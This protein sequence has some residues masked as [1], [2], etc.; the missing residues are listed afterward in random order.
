M[1]D[2]ESTADRMTNSKT[3]LDN[4]CRLLCGRLTNLKRERNVFSSTASSSPHS[5]KKVTFFEDGEFVTQN[6]GLTSIFPGIFHNISELFQIV[7]NS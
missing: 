2:I 3:L 5:W 1:Y 7:Q 6:L 4:I